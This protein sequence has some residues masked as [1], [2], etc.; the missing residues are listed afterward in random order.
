VLDFGLAKLT[1][2]S[3][4]PAA[5]ASLPTEQLTGA[6]QIVGTVAYMSPEQAEGRP[7]DHR[8]DIF[9]LGIILYEL[10]TGARPFAGESS[11]AV[12]SSIL[13]DTPPLVNEVNPAI[14]EAVARLIRR[15]LEKHVSQRFQSALDLKHGLDDVHD[16]APVLAKPPRMVSPVVSDI[17]P[18]R[19]R[20]AIA[21]T[22]VALTVA[23]VG[24]G[25]WTRWAAVSTD[26]GD[27]ASP[28][29][30]PVTV[31][32]F[33]NR[34]GDASLDS[35]GQ[36]LADA[37][38]QELP[39]LPN[40]MR[41]SDTGR[42]PFAADPKPELEHGVVSGAYY[43]DGPNLRIQASLA[44]NA[45]NVLQAIEPAIGPR[46]DPGKAVDLAQQRILGAVVA[47]LDPDLAKPSRPPLYGAYREFKAGMFLFGDEPA[48][49]VEHH[50]KAADLDPGFF[51]AWYGAALAYNNLGDSR[52][53]REVVDRMRAMNDRWGAKERD[54]VAFISYSLDGQMADALNALRAAESEDP[55]DLSTNY[56]IGYYLVRLNQPQAAIDQY[57]K[58]DAKS[59]DAV[60]VGT[61]R[62]ARLA[63][64]NHLLG[65]HEE[66]LR[67]ARI[68]RGLFP[69]S[70]FSRNDELTA[71]AALGRL[72]DLR[73]AADDTR[74]M[75]AKDGATPAASMRVAAEELRAHG[76]HGES[77]GM[78]Q[79]AVAWYRNRPPDFLTDDSNRLLLAQSLY[80]AEEWTEAGEIT[81]SLLRAQPDNMAYT[82]LAGAVAARLG[83]RAAAM[84]HAATL[85]QAPSTPGG[86]SELRRAQLAALLGRREQAVSLLRDAF[87]RG[88]SMSAGLHRQMDLESLRG[89][90]PFDE[91]MK[92]KR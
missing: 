41:G 10:A 91:L 30:N 17:T 9:S 80:V 33:Q 65:R 92:P 36:M 89:F 42:V 56:L 40:V 49:A 43:L 55:N 32:R 29:T 21:G 48:K 5:L 78:A 7:V 58:V 47:A 84:K 14:P 23:T 68:A 16:A 85:D 12:L 37:L 24:Y 60:T 66:E 51:L 3:D 11:I 63:T 62:Y 59:W 4:N 64:A 86:T 75:A 82:A 72:D 53:S 6:G 22:L 44:G 76:H 61:W 70:F 31:T 71:L 69:T 1:E 8:S 73:R 45:G 88:L 79:Q 26:A 67:V 54:L 20:A 35:V 34:T 77:I 50:L 15:C 52:R 87:A 38:A 13:R 90:E 2:S 19:S 74:T 46:T 83:N 39:R 57:A 25:T 28:A 27:V 81:A 18:R